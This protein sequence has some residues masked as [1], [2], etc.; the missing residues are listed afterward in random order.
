MNS[1]DMIVALN[2]VL[3][4]VDYLATFEQGLL[5]G[6]TIVAGCIGVNFLRTIDDNSE[7]T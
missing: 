6:A 4:N 7:D 3:Q 1:N 5:L 2:A